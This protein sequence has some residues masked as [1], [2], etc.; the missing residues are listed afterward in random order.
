M[1]C[2]CVQEGE[3]TTI[4]KSRMI[5][6]NVER[7][8]KNGPR[9][10]KRK[11][12]RSAIAAASTLRK[13]LSWS[14]LWICIPIRYL[15]SWIFWRVLFLKKSWNYIWIKIEIPLQKRCC[16]NMASQAAP[17]AATSIRTLTQCTISTKNGLIL[18]RNTIFEWFLWVGSETSLNFVNG[19]L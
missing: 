1:P 11:R 19:I 5:L 18:F 12:R 9:K 14:W 7:M 13:N 10:I 16:P 4:I 15:I 8:M 3:D 17:A 2:S 6:A